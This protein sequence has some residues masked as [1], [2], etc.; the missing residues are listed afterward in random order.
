MI[1]QKNVLVDLVLQEIKKT[2]DKTKKVWYNIHIIKNKGEF[3]WIR[4]SM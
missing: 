2:L 3:E 1:Q 4:L